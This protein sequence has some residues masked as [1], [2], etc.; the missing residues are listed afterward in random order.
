MAKATQPI[1]IADLTLP[2]EVEAALVDKITN[3]SV[4]ATLCGQAPMTFTD[5]EYLV[6]TTEPHAELVAE[7]A[8]KASAEAK[9]TPI[10]GNRYK[11]QTTVRMNEEVRWADE[12][13]QLQI[14]DRIT[15]SMGR[16]IGEAV[17]YIALHEIDPLSGAKASAISGQGLDS[18]A[19]KITL[20]GDTITVPE[21]DALPDS[22]IEAGYAPNGVAFDPALANQLRKMRT[23]DGTLQRLYPDVRMDLQVGNFE[24]LRSVTSG[25]VSGDALAAEKTGILA[26]MGK[27]DLI[28]W[29]FVRNIALEEITYGDPDGLGDLKRYNQVAYR[30]EAVFSVV[31]FDPK[32]FTVLAK[33]E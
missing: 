19:K 20:A 3:Q 29:G 2:T 9:F 32:G 12:D 26:Y 14:L 23:T 15:E 7:G 31:N 18:V 24:G 8:A 22:I 4:I 27:W 13:S 17:D 30:T 21:I 25:N 1:K 5:K 28:R 11:V 6:F 16:S 10:V 33:N